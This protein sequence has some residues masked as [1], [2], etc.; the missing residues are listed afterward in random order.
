M[1]AATSLFQPTVDLLSTSLFSS[2]QT[3]SPIDSAV[4]SYARAK[5]IG[6]AYSGCLSIGKI[7]L[8]KDKST[9]LTINDISELNDKF[10]DMHRDPTLTSDGAAGV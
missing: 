2:S 9:D 6:R 3:L 5:A 7:P 10:W 1:Q 8:L 4:R